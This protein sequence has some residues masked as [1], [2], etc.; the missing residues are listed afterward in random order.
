MEQ[1]FASMHRCCTLAWLATCVVGVSVVGCSHSSF[2]SQV[3]GRVTLDG[4]TIGP[5][6]VV[7]AATESGKGNPARGT[8]QPNGGYTLTTAN[9]SGLNSGK[10]KVSVSVIDEPPPPPGVRNMTLGKQLV[11]EKFTDVN[12]S[13]LQFEVTPGSN[14][15]NIELTSK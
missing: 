2:D 11:P 3:S 15:I 12:S 1:R 6:V 10:Y 4:K 8:I 14:T 7:F 9:A 5:G 13:G